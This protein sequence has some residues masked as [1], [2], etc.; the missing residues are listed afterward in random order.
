MENT[1]MSAIEAAQYLG[2]SESYLAKLRM[3]TFPEA[4]PAFCRIGQRAIRYR[5][6]DLDVWMSSRIER[7]AE[8]RND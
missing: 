2:L 6:S 7:V 4:G 1:Y 3:G 8:V 5:K